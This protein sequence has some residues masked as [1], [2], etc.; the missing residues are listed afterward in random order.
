MIDTIVLTFKKPIFAIFDHKKFNPPTNHLY[1]EN[2]IFGSKSFFKCVQN[3]S[4]AELKSGIY[5]PR[6]TVFKRIN[7]QGLKEINLKVEFSAPKL[8][9]LNN[10]DELDENNFSELTA[11]LKSVLKDMGVFIFEE[12]IKKAPISAVHYSKNIILE[13]YSNP[14]YY[15]SQLKNLNI[16]K[17]LDTNQSDYRNDGLSFKYRANSYEVVF[18]D[19]LHDLKQTK[20]SPKRSEEKEDNLL[21]LNI[22]DWI[23]QKQKKPFEVLRYEIRL[24][25]RQ[26]ILHIFKKIGLNYNLSDITFSN[27]FKK[28]ISKKVLLYFLKEISEDFNM[29]KSV[30]GNDYK[31]IFFEIL[32]NLNG[33][34]STALKVFGAYILADKYGQRELKNILKN[35]YFNYWYRLKKQLFLKQNNSFETIFSPIIKQIEEFKPVKLENCK[36]MINNYKYE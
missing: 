20:I 1:E 4:I 14:Y 3:P 36:L 23:N 17:K 26:K 2:N 16:N 11:K 13:D 32:F 29:L 25:N 33:K 30:F 12:F 6:L 31:K 15:I 10:F 24:N 22:L 28:E 34:I 18:Y 9:Y 21:Q 5:K 35:Q 27:L 19:K 7:H 8:L